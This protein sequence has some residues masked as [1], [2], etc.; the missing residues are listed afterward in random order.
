MVP[1]QWLLELLQLVAALVE[2]VAALVVA[3]LLVQMVVRAA[4]VAGNKTGVEL[5]LRDKVL[6]VE[7][8][9]ATTPVAVV[10][11]VKQEIRTVLD[12]VATESKVQLQD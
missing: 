6:P 11:Q 5:V 10:A 12:T 9:L 2:M 3:V 1:I 7:P 8:H 4:A